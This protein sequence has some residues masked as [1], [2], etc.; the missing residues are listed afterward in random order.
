MRVEI[1]CF[2]V[3]TI[4]IA[5]ATSSA[6]LKNEKERFLVSASSISFTTFTLI[7]SRT[8]VS[9]TI[10]LTTTC[11]TSTATL[12]TCTTGRRRRGVFYDEAET[13]SRHRRAALFYKE[14]DIDNNEGTIFLP[15]E[16]K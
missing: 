6:V 12:L 13:N 8:T 9:S 14:E 7:K 4:V 3:L 5:F 15:V 1:I 2:F 16:N 11:T 10:T